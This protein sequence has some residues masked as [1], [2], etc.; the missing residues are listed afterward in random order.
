VI[1][2]ISQNRHLSD[3]LALTDA[4]VRF[5][6]GLP[7]PQYVTDSGRVVPAIFVALAEQNVA[8]NTFCP[9][10]LRGRTHVSVP[11]DPAL[12]L[13]AYFLR[14]EYFEQRPALVT[15][16]VRGAGGTSLRLRADPTVDFD[17]QLGVVLLPITLGRP[18]S[19]TF[20]SDGDA[21]NVCMSKVT[22]GYPIA[23]HP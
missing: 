15:V 4:R 11:L 17:Q 9:T 22:V 20:S 14:I 7:Q 23:A 2:I 8:P 6:R 18:T 19:V 1:P 21:T 10:L 5:D 3:L 13:G 16:V 12:A